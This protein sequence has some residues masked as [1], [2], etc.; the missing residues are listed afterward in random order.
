[1]ETQVDI[2]NEK[3]KEAKEYI[4]S[5]QL[6]SEHLEGMTKKK[7]KLALTYTELIELK[8]LAQDINDLSVKIASSLEMNLSKRSEVCRFFAY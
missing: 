7:S 3:F 2:R 1:M 6:E 8:I 5:A 4:S